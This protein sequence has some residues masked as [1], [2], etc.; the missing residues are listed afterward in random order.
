LCRKT[1]I[2]ISFA[3][4]DD[5]RSDFE[6]QKT[7]LEWFPHTPA[8]FWSDTC[9]EH[10]GF[11]GSHTAISYPVASLKSEPASSS[12][13]QTGASTPITSAVGH[14]DLVSTYFRLIVK[15]L[16]WP[17]GQPLPTS[18]WSSKEYKWHE[19]EFMSSSSDS[20]ST[21]LCFDVPE[22][23]IESI[24]RTL[25]AST[26]QYGGPFGLHVPLL[27]ELV[28]LYDR[29]V[30]SMAKKVRDIEMVSGDGPLEDIEPDDTFV[31]TTTNR[32]KSRNDSQNH[33]TVGA[34]PPVL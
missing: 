7:L 27:E 14:Q 25:S 31:L 12:T 22:D 3:R 19:M 13:T 2:V 28:K 16:E 15:I 11:F 20:R 24:Q 29:S 30:W 5:F 18:A 21:V 34:P 32:R 33:E 1:D 6:R 26:E 10:N 4:L 8:L 23:V 17:E 9:V